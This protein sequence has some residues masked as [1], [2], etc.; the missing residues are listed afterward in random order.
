[1]DRP[2][3]PTVCCDLDNTLREYWDV[4]PG[5]FDFLGA[6]RKRGRRLILATTSFPK[7]VEDFWK[8]HF[9]HI[10]TAEDFPRGMTTQKDLNL[11]RERISPESP[12]GVN[13]LMVGDPHEMWFSRYD[14]PT[15][16][17]I[18]PYGGDWLTRERTTLLCDAFLSPAPQSPGGRFDAFWHSGDVV[19]FNFSRH[20]HLMPTPARGVRRCVIN[21][22]EF[23]LAVTAEEGRLVLE[24]PE[25]L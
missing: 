15:P 14:P 22:G 13:M 9:D 23:L 8:D 24:N 5:A 11:I 1:M 18:V 3:E 12:D 21:G 2:V 7:N 19:S 17:V 4:Y 6:Q 16:F 20:F 25:L 10:F